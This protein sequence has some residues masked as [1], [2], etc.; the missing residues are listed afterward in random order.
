MVPGI[1]D[2]VR[3][4]AGLDHI[5]PSRSFHRKAIEARFKER[6]DEGTRMALELHDTFLQTGHA[7]GHVLQ[8]TSTNLLASKV[9]IPNGIGESSANCMT[10]IPTTPRCEQSMIVWK[11]AVN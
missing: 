6:L 9:R 1:V 10:S 8:G 5:S 4:S 7:C 2:H 11:I 3:V